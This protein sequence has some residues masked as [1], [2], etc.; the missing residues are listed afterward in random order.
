MTVAT[1]FAFQNT[2]LIHD[3]FASRLNYLEFEPSTEQFTTIEKL[4]SGARMA[5][6]FRRAYTWA[7][8]RSRDLHAEALQYQEQGDGY[9]L[10][11]GY[12]EYMANDQVVAYETTRGTAFMS[13]A[14]GSL[15]VMLPKSREFGFHHQAI[16]LAMAGLSY[17]RIDAL[18]NIHRHRGDG[19]FPD[20]PF[21]NHREAFDER[22]RVFDSILVPL[23]FDPQET[24]EESE[25]RKASY[26]VGFT[27]E[28][29]EAEIDEDDYIL[30]GDE[31]A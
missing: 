28:D 1:T 4:C 7:E 16:A 26:D 9:C 20:S 18:F 6:N 2:D 5:G 17:E 22:N 11:M 14:D 13:F 29:R 8:N 15:G 12:C 21:A 23:G 19:H 25:A 24:W 27:D 31:E 3:L 10:P 30:T